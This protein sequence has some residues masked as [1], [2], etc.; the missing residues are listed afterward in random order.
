[1]NLAP[2]GREIDVE[3]AYTVGVLGGNLGANVYLRR[4]PGNVRSM[5]N[6]IGSAIR[7]TLG[8]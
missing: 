7:F 6:D 1:M 2:T 8:F 3:A 4:Q 5:P